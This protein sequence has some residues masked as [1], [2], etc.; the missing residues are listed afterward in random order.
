MTL[1]VKEEN[2][3]NIVSIIRIILRDP[4]N[5]TVGQMLKTRKK[6]GNETASEFMWFHEGRKYVTNM[7]FVPKKYEYTHR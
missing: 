1:I 7:T 2:F 3:K 6:K 5:M 4:R